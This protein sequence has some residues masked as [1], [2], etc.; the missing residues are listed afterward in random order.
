MIDTNGK[1][2][3]NNEG[4]VIL[5]LK[6]AITALLIRYYKVD[7]KAVESINTESMASILYDEINLRLDINIKDT[8]RG[9]MKNND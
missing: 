6:K 9:S 2:R 5:E 1:P 8:E 7:E 3:P 4:V